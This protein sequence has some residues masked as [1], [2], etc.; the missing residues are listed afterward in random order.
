MGVIKPS[1]HCMPLVKR[2]RPS[3]LA[4][5][6]TL[7]LFTLGLHRHRCGDDDDHEIMVMSFFAHAAL[8]NNDDQ[9]TS[10]STTTAATTVSR[11][12]NYYELLNLESP[13]THR[14]SRTS[15]A[16][17]NRK[18]RSTY[19]SKIGTSDIK[20]AYRKQAQMYHPD[21]ARNMNIT[22]QEATSR[23]AEIAEAYQILIDPQQRYHMIGNY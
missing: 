8:P 20:K 2:R 16:L 10:S 23:F 22:T 14:R 21:K 9:P 15:S 17:N 11:P 7:A 4:V 19:R 13:D 3:C 18:K 5:A 12:P 6:C 1:K